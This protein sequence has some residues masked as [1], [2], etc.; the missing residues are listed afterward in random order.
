MNVTVQLTHPELVVQRFG[1]F[2]AKLYESNPEFA[3]RFVYTQNLGTWGAEVR[4]FIAGDRLTYSS[5]I[6]PIQSPLAMMIIKVGLGLQSDA[7]NSELATAMV[8]LRHK[9]PFGQ[10]PG[11]WAKTNDQVMSLVHRLCRERNFY[12]DDADLRL[13]S[14]KVEDLIT[15]PLFGTPDLDTHKPDGKLSL[16]LEYEDEALTGALCLALRMKLVKISVNK[17]PKPEED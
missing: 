11:W 5:K 17:T 7:P 13:V 9:H 8:K 4:L 2:D 6:A 3:Q 15:A 12:Y 16:L 1:I 10:V 14:E